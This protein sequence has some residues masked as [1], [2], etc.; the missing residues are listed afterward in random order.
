MYLIIHVQATQ[1]SGGLAAERDLVRF[2]YLLY[3]INFVNDFKF[4]MRFVFVIDI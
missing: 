1:A 3:M 4:Q 2:S